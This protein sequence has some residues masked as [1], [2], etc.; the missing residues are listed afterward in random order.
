MYMDRKA[1]MIEFFAYSEVG[2]AIANVGAVARADFSVAS[3][4]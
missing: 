4:E 3:S 1:F 2:A